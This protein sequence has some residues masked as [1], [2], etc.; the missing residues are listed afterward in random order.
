MSIFCISDQGRT[1]VGGPVNPPLNLIFYKNFITCEKKKIV[2][3]YICLLICRLNAT[4]ME[5]N[6]MQISSNIVK[7][8]KS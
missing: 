5:W 6:C 4:T 3:P 7:L 1:Q 2:F 8:A